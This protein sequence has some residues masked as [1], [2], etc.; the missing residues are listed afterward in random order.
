MTTDLLF[1][2][3]RTPNI[4]SGWA[5]QTWGVEVFLSFF[6]TVN[7]ISLDFGMM[8]ELNNQ[9]E[10]SWDKQR[11]KRV[12]K[13]NTERKQHEQEMERWGIVYSLPLIYCPFILWGP[14]Q[15]WVSRS[16]LHILAWSLPGPPQTG[17]LCLG[18]L[19]RELIVFKVPWQE[20]DAH[21][22]WVLSQHQQL[23]AQL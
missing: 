17:P 10:Q 8:V 1:F 5:S 23:G 19:E 7:L 13:R 20:S 16:G 3:A 15:R 4:F 9:F 18:K 6:I 14:D 12:T 2:H 21:S 22:H 11:T